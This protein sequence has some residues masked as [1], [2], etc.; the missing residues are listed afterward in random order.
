MA[1]SYMG[2][3]S[4]GKYVIARSD[5]AEQYIPFITMF[6][7]VLKGDKS[8]WFSWNL[9]SGSGTALLYA[10]YTLSPFNLLYLIL[11]ENHIMTATALVIIL[12]ASLASAMFQIF[13]TRFLK[14][15]GYSS[16]LFAMMYGLC[17]YQVCYYF[18][19]I[20]MDA[21]YMFP[22]ICLLVVVLV[23]E[24]RFILLIPAYAYLFAT[25]FYAGYMAGMCSFIF[26]LFYLSYC[27]KE[28]GWK[29]TLRNL[30]KFASAVILA[31]GVTAVIWLPAV[32]ILFGGAGDFSLAIEE[33]HCNPLFL[34]NNLF[35]GQMQSLHG[36][37][38]FI[39][40]G[41]P[42]LFLMPFYFLNKKISKRERRYVLILIVLLA[43]IL[44]IPITNLFMHG[45][46]DADMFRYR[47]SYFLS[48]ILCI[49]GYR[50]IQY[51]FQI[52]KKK[53]GIWL[54]CN[55]IIYC[56][57]YYLY[58]LVWGEIYNSNTW[59]GLGINILFV[60]LWVMCMHLFWNRKQ[61]RTTCFL[62]MTVLLMLE[63]GVNAGI[64]LSKME[65]IPM[66]QAEYEEQEKQY[67]TAV[68]NLQENA[69][70]LYRTEYF[71]NKEMNPCIRY[72]YCGIQ[73]F[74]SSDM[75]DWADLLEK[76][77]FYHSSHVIS[78]A[79]MTEITG[80][81]LGVKYRIEGN[82]MEYTADGRKFQP[83]TELPYVLHIGYMVKDD[84]L[85]YESVD[86]PFANQD[87]LLSM[88]CGEKIRCYDETVAKLKATNGI[89][90]EQENVHVMAQ[91]PD[92]EL[93]QFKFTMEQSRERPLYVYFSQLVNGNKALT[94]V[95]YT[96]DFARLNNYQ[97]TSLVLNPARIIKAGLDETGI[98]DVTIMF[99]E[100]V[101]DA[102]FVN[103]YFCYYNQEELVKAYDVLKESQLKI[104]AYQEDG[105]TGTVDA[106]ENEILFVSIP[107]DDGW[108]V[109]VDGQKQEKI[110]VVENAFIGIRLSQGEHEIVLKYEAPGAQLGLSVSVICMA[111]SLVLVPWKQ[112]LRKKDI[113]EVA[114]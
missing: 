104:T 9:N 84:V 52:N 102:Y 24:G 46:D 58:Q 113:E 103:G 33:T 20:W 34:Y 87:N 90:D 74:T 88:M 66:K 8:Y 5:L 3:L 48:F 75:T 105:L 98:Y 73:N 69:S 2:L 13:V 112:I 83:Y 21:F 109:W 6:C 10:Y 53:I 108:K 11:G 14:R 55:A 54:S 94:P 29:I 22:L 95:V 30:L 7:D 28:N 50:Q 38:P 64:C 97:S 60:M 71:N 27:H 91:K 80:M 23:R 81:L 114:F 68:A 35:M 82:I 101:K 44:L 37:T 78:D 45:M 1:F 110:P 70:G 47:Y 93:A 41:I 89:Y 107:Y 56:I 49:I 17:G 4:N 72:G 62:L 85:E 99:D 36:M 42:A 76:L 15:S 59:W 86:S 67:R 43:T 63:L 106:G 31:V 40:C 79:G 32:K 77:G 100:E 12:K 57:A 65:H 19:I 92:E 51:S 25:N 16:V 26:F 96:P 61:S 111:I 39:Y 18:N